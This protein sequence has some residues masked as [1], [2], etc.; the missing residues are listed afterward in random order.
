MSIE[1]HSV[2]EVIVDV[3]SSATDRPFDYLIPEELASEVHVGS[4]VQV[5]FGPRKLL[6]YV[7]GLKDHSSSRRLKAIED[8]MDLVPPLTPELVRL[9]MFMAD[10][11]LCRTITA[12]QSMVPAVLKG[13]YQKVVRLHPAGSEREQSLL[14]ISAHELL[15]RLNGKG[16]CTWEEALKIPGINRSLLR[17]LEE[18]K[19]IVIEERIGD[20]VTRQKVIRVWPK[21]SGQ[22]PNSLEQLSPRAVRQREVIR[23]FMEHPEKIDLPALLSQVQATRST[24][25][26]LVEQGLLAWEEREQYRDPYGDRAFTPTSPLPLT[27]EQQRAFDAIVSPLREKRYHPILLHGVTGSGKTEIYLQAI[28]EVL[29]LGR[30]AVVLVPEISLTP[31]MVAR[32]KG[33]FGAQVAVLHSGLSGGERYDEWRKIRSGEVKVAIG[34]RSAI[35]APFQNLGLI[36]IDEEHESSYKQEENPKYHAREIARWRAKEHGA[37]L[38]LGSATPAVETYYLARTGGYEWVTLTERVHGRPFP[39]VEVVDM[40]EELRRGNRTMFSSLLRDSL[41]ECVNRGEQAVLFLNRRGFS[42]FVM[43]RECGE[44][45]MC[46][47]CDISLTYHQTNRTVRCHYCGYA[48]RI[49]SECPSCRSR[50]IRHFGAG[51]QRVEEELAR[52]F[53]GLR[54]I[55]MDVDTTSRK[56]AHEKLLTAFAEGKADVLLGTQMIAKGLDFPRVTLVGVIAADTML[57]LPDFRAAERTFQ[58]LTQVSGRAGRHEQ[59]GKVIIQTYSADHYS[60]G[61]AAT[62]QMEDFYRRECLTRKQHHYPPFCG[63]FTL[64]LSHPD[65]VMLMKAGQEAAQFIRGRLPQAAE[66]LG[67]VPAAIPKLKDRYR[68]QMLIKFTPSNE[69]LS[70]LKSVLK[71]LE[72]GFDD[73]ELR[74]SI[75]REGICLPS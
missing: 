27:A 50:H 21:D 35:F 73:A 39:Q 25:Q 15:E 67:P 53:P 32:F 54:V 57:H 29:S 28:D 46:P 66:L 65:R 6:G 18:A 12:L 64:L 61:M 40:R 1:Y 49:P 31:Q 42:T 13:R 11:Y 45:L 7:V 36:I 62:Y 19:R 68:L 10:E 5:P 56:G 63:L 9:G 74:I 60:I 47:H 26:K 52:R 37:T 20:R 70:Q 75:D 23:F 16:E 51:T 41:I 71:Q 38:V 2:A 55:R 44:T 72:Q 58:L 22:L 34:A 17:Q 59:P 43:C 69:S 4:R 8:V 33:R 48:D 14:S 30:E 24:V 3:P